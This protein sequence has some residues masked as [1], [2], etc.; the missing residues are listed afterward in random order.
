M[1][2]LLGEVSIHSL[3]T[4]QHPTANPTIDRVARVGEIE[5]Q[6]GHCE[7]DGKSRPKSE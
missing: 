2:Y 1:G 3:E 7:D 5:Q 4:L 6:C